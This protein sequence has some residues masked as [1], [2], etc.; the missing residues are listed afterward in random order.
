MSGQFD[1]IVIGGGVLGASTAYH[2]SAEGLRVLLLDKDESLSG[3]S[4][5]TFAWCGAHLKSP[6]SYNLMSQQAIA[7]YGSLEAELEADLEYGRVG[8][9]SLL[10]PGD[11]DEWRG[12]IGEM[13]AEGYR[14][15][16]LD[17]AQ[18]RALEPSAPEM[19]AGGLHCPIDVEINPF[20][21]V[22]AYL[23]KARAQGAVLRYGEEVTALAAGPPHTVTTNQGE[24]SAPRLVL[25]GG[26]HSA[27]LGALI[28]CEIPV[29]QSRGQ[30]LV[31]ERAPR[32]FNGFLGLRRAPTEGGFMLRQVSSGNVLVGYTEEK[33]GFDRRVTMSG[34]RLLADNAMAG[35]P[36]L[37]HLQVIRVYAGIRPMPADGLPILSELPGRPGMILIATHSGYTLSVL[38]GRT[39]AN[40]LAGKDQSGYFETYGLS[41]F[42]QQSA[43]TPLA[44]AG[45][46]GG[47]SP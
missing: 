7:M 21:L 10:L 29:G 32:M 23:R 13:Q 11:Y 4:G 39:V 22:A 9:I 20:L 42:A 17:F 45:S 12:R 37:A 27:Q 46:F 35:F 15:E 2:C 30:I 31:T 36:P 34:M 19:Y 5:A 43:A 41:R 16:L 28:G 40:R 24:Y 25:A 1:L 44:A 8:S 26:I 38:V 18:L 47:G 14:L 6:A 33:V 3:T